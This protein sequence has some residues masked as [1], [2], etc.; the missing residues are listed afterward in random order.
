M[1]MRALQF[2]IVF[3]TPALVA[4]QPAS[5]KA[6]PAASRAVSDPLGR[7]TP[8]GAVKGFLRA[9]RDNNYEAAAQFLEGYRDPKLAR[10]LQAV[11]DAALAVNLNEISDDPAGRFDTG[12]GGERERIGAVRVGGA[13]LDIVLRR[14]NGLW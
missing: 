4:A 14:V 10:Q 3:L 9:A 1:H 5:S 6:A 8:R 7:S 12:L 11:L 2:L 13:T